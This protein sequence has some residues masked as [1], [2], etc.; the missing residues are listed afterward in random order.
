[1]RLLRSIVLVQFATSLGLAQAGHPSESA[2]LPNRPI[3]LVRSLY[4]QVVVRHP[5]GIPSGEDMKVF[6]PYM[7]KE[8][9]HKIDLFLACNDD[10]DRQHRDPDL[11][12]KPPF[13]VWESGIFSGGDE[14]TAPGWFHI[15]RERPERDGS[16]RVLVK[17]TWHDSPPFRAWE[18]WQVAAV[19]VR[20]DNHLVVDDI[21][22]LKDKDRPEESDR[23]LSDDLSHYCDGP[24]WVGDGSKQIPTKP[25]RGRVIWV[26]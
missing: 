10:W 4:A 15:E 3:A 17:L 16:L 2:V 13:G 24:H 23:R 19:L 22:Y 9:L 12:E 1:M 25:L 18:V 11:P 21:I 7:S 14:R 8:L 20:E 5:G 6:A 26:H